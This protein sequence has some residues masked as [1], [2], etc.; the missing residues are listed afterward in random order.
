MPLV[1]VGAVSRLEP[2]TVEEVIIGDK[3]FALCNVEGRI[4]ALN[5]ACLHLGGPLGQG[6]ISGSNVV[7]P[8][9]GWEFNC[10]SGEND[11]DPTQRVETYPVQVE[12]GDILVDLP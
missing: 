9:H 2:G 3:V 12:H 11:Y 4:T 6:A 10:A 8:W 5:G 7:C 1:K